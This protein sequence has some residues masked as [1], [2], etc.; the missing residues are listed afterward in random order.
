MALRTFLRTLG[1]NAPSVDTVT[2]TG[3][4]LPGAPLDLTVHLRGGGADLDVERLRLELVV[5]AE[6]READGSTAWNNP[7][8]VTAVTEGPFRL[9]AGAHLTREVRVDVPWTMPF[10]HAR[11]ERLRGSRVAVRTELAVDGAVDRGDFDEIEVHALPAQDMLFGIY[12]DLGFRFH[13]S[14]VKVFSQPWPERYRS[15]RSTDYW[16]E[17][18]FHFPDSWDYKGWELET[19]LITFADELDLHPGGNPPVTLSYADMDR[20]KWAQAVERHVRRHWNR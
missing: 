6:D 17:L 2:G 16:Q 15:R 4:I 10:T 1:S 14:E 5:R 8:V 18:D 20:E 7:Y 12:E 11:G 3:R 9:P 19:V 13:E